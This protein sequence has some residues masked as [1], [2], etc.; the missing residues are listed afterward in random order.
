M[1]TRNQLKDRYTRLN[2]RIAA[3]AE[4][5]GRRAADVM[6]IAVTKLASPSQIRQ[7]VELGHQDLGESRVQQLQ[8]RAATLEEFLSRHRMLTSGRQSTMPDQVR[9]HMI[10]H[11]QRN[12]VKP[13]LPLVKLIHS[14][15]SLRLAEEIQTH[16]ARADR[17]VEVLLQVNASGESQK[18]GLAPAAVP[19]L[20]EQIMTMLHVKVRG[21]MTMGPLSDDP[22]S[23]R[24]TFERTAELFNEMRNSGD[25]GRDFN[26]LSMGMS[27][28][29]EIAIECGA[30]LLRIGKALFGEPVGAS[31]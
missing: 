7:I 3:A 16:A 27:E 19:Y 21:L 29:F 30:N 12:K 8:Q 22:E 15:D 23:A 17:D 20:A 25:F 13:T 1:V 11:L 2:E 6:T 31:Q 18:F 4:R 26:I 28:D 10:G 24:P 5:S 14:V 9:W